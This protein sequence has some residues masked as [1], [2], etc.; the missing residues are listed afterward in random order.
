M[1]F[2]EDVA[3]AGQITPAVAMPIFPTQRAITGVTFLSHKC[4]IDRHN[5]IAE[6]SVTR[7]N[8]VLKDAE[9]LR[10]LIKVIRD[11]PLT[12][13]SD[14]EFLLTGED[15]Y[16]PA[17]RFISDPGHKSKAGLDG[18]PHVGELRPSYGTPEEH[19]EELRLCLSEL[20]SVPIRTKAGS[21]A[22][23]GRPLG[24]HLHFNIPPNLQVVCALEA[25]VGH[26]LRKYSARSLVGR[27]GRPFDIEIKPWGFEY[28]S[29][30]SWVSH[31]DLTNMVITSSW[32]IVNTSRKNHMFVPDENGWEFIVNDNPGYEPVL[33][34]YKKSVIDSPWTNFET[35]DILSAWGID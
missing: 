18:Y 20:R 28:R 29:L 24:G 19:M 32:C 12:I 11:I 2:L 22:Y 17:D 3:E 8:K 31:P 1:T 7:D 34:A 27:F 5:I 10:P 35:N 15:T 21:G 30:P 33:R 6:V 13:G 14:P 9:T 23:Y 25:F 16:V 4:S 26:P